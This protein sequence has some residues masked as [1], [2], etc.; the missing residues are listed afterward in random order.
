MVNWESSCTGKIYLAVCVLVA[1]TITFL[2]AYL[3][4]DVKHGYPLSISGAKK[5]MPF[6]QVH[7]NQYAVQNASSYSVWGS[8]GSDWQWPVSVSEPLKCRHPGIVKICGKPRKR[9][10]IL[11]YQNEPDPM[12]RNR[13][14]DGL[15]HF[16]C[17]D[18]VDMVYTSNRSLFAMADAVE[19]P[20]KYLPTMPT[21]AKKI[22]AFH[23]N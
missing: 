5:L 6:L 14:S 1:S 22:S 19:F 11:F 23:G 13:P 7:G 4:L 15:S 16:G 10:L 21:R 17:C 3:L 12:L 9:F 20:A 8:D 2:A 18:G